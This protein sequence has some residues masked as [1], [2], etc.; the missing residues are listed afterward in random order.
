MPTQKEIK[1]KD[2]LTLVVMPVKKKGSDKE[3]IISNLNAVLPNKLLTFE[4]ENIN[5]M[6]WQCIHCQLLL[7]I[8]FV[9]NI[10]PICLPKLYK[11][12][13][14]CWH[15]RYCQEYVENFYK[16][17][18]HTLLH[19]LERI[20]YLLLTFTNCLNKN[21]SLLVSFCSTKGLYLFR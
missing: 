10:V 16:L 7:V 15:C 9:D 12:K 14:R 3:V 13:K 8:N 2:V 1:A 18:V 4:I 6:R 20:G 21:I 19:S 11:G 17:K 5:K